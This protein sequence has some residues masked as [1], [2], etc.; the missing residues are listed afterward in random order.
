VETYPFKWI[1][2]K[3]EKI[4]VNDLSKQLEELGKTNI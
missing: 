2:E 1:L 4:K 3:R